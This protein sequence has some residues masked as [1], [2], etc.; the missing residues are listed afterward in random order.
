MHFLT[1]NCSAA[2]SFLSAI[3][4][5]F[6]KAVLQ[7]RWQGPDLG[8]R[9]I[10]S[11]KNFADDLLSLWQSSQPLLGIEKYCH[12]GYRE[13]FLESLVQFTWAVH[14]ALNGC[15]DCCLKMLRR[16]LGDQGQVM[17]LNC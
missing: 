4:L 3:L 1:H 12:H 7:A 9:W 13:E 10:H 16:W 14:L 2:S 6:T 15:D 11:Q 8:H 5:L 17:Q